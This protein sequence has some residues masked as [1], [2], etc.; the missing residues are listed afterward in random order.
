MLRYGVKVVIKGFLGGSW[1]LVV[2]SCSLSIES[3]LP[4]DTTPVR[5]EVTKLVLTATALQLGYSHH[6]DSVA[7]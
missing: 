2:I 1:D 7:H 5:S 6:D 4:D 3:Q